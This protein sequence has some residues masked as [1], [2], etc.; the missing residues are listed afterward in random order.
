[1]HTPGHTPGHISL[2]REKDGALIVGDA[3]STVDQQSLAK[4]L[5]QYREFA[6]PPAYAT[7]DWRAARESIER[8]AELRPRYVACGHGQPIT[9]RST[10]S[11]LESFARDFRAPEHGRYVAQPAVADESG[12]REVPPPASDPVLKI[13][14]AVAIGGAA[15]AAGYAL[16]RRRAA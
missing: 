11:R 4:T 7:T 15:L 8:L 3:F 14:A 2:F 9:G 13:A 1:V 5:T 6:S 10:A 12:V 16:K